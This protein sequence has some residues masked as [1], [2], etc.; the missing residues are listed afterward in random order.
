[1]AK[2]E[3]F[4]H[5]SIQ[6]NES[7][8]AYLESLIDGFKKGKIVLSVDSQKIELR[9]NNLLHFDLNARKKGSKSKLTIKLSWRDSDPGESSNNDVSISN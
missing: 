6:D 7:V 9:P 8:G 5:E 4:E 3:E 1:M 2:N